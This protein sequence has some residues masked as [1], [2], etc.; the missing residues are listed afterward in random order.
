[1]NDSNQLKLKATPI[2]TINRPFF[3]DVW[4]L[5]NNMFCIHHRA[6]AK[7]YHVI[8]QDIFQTI[9]KFIG[10]Y[11][12]CRTAILNCARFAF[13]LGDDKLLVTNI[14]TFY[15][16]LFAI[17]WIKKKTLQRKLI[18][19][20]KTSLKNRLCQIKLTT[21]QNKFYK[22][23]FTP[24]GKQTLLVTNYYYLLKM[25]PHPYGVFFNDLNVCSKR[26]RHISM[27]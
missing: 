18:I 9:Y 25:G 17:I 23:I 7:F 6:I 13:D 21:S 1:M 26:V 5:K 10:S 22:H 8:V 12:Q 20:Q 15:S 3:A 27:S 24:S 14:Q 2:I 4:M 19:P 16:I 11:P